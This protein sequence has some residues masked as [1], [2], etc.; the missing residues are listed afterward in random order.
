MR[1]DARNLNP[2]AEI[3]NTLASMADTIIVKGYRSKSVASEIAAQ[4]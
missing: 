2:L 3:P 1:A 4:E